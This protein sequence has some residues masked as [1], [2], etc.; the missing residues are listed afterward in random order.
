MLL[1]V[2]AGSAAAQPEPSQADPQ[3]LFRE[4]RRKLM[5]TIKRLPRYMCTQT[6]ERSMFKPKSNIA[7]RS[8]DDLATRRMSKDWALRRFSFD[9][10][11]LDVSVS[12]EGEMYSWAG[13][14]RFQDRTLAEL[15]RG[16]TTSTGTFS[17]FLASIFGASATTF[18]Y[19]GKVPSGNRMLVAFA[20]RIPLE[21]STYQIGDEFQKTVV[22]YSGTFLVDSATFDL[23]RLTIGVDSLP[24]SLHACA[25]TTTLEYGK[26]QINDAEFLLPIDAVL[27]IIHTDGTELENRTV[28]SG[29]HEFVGESSIRFDDE[30]AG[31]PMT[32]SEVRYPAPD[33]P[34][35]I[36]FRLTLSKPI[37]TAS[38]AAGDS[39][40]ARLAT[41]IKS[42]KG[43]I[44]LSKDAE[45]SGRIVSFG[46]TFLESSELLTA[47]LRLDSVQIDG[48][49]HGFHANLASSLRI[50]SKGVDHIMPLEAIPA[51]RQ[52]RIEDSDVGF[53]H[54][55]GAG[56]HYIIRRGLEMEG[57]TASPK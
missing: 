37:A 34:A 38:A 31:V 28:F 22:A 53:L 21:K 29:C 12:S 10:L 1:C 23:V 33:I 54:F 6:T 42:K 41:P 40:K 56:D 55:L 5:L 15:V 49:I 17:S 51:F 14:N 11:R 9:R 4:V 35:G 24:D 43:D 2:L 30:F 32:G 7:V 52:N 20:Y 39:F 36:R 18:S 27:H 13:E 57:V 44:L 8:C 3:T 48:R 26:I 47:A 16:G 45:L 46:R 50:Y 25:D 19:A